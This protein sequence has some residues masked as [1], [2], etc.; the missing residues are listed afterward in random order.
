LKLLNKVS[1]EKKLIRIGKIIGVHGV[2]GTLKVYPFVESL[3][4][5]EPG[6]SVTLRSPE[7]VDAPYVLTQATPHKKVVLLILEGVGRNAAERLVP[8]EI[9]IEKERLP[10]LEADVYYWDDI[11][12][13][14]VYEENGRFVGT[15]ASI[16]ETGSNDVYVVRYKDREVLIP[17]L[18][19]VI[20]AIDADGGRMTVDLP[21]GLGIQ[22]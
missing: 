21:E 18:S 2:R 13:L 9:L 4:L 16:I 1:E 3:D 6:A 14:E 8:S 19:S 11:I 10:A 15:I 17:A 12:G 22:A 5:F 20:V 7:G